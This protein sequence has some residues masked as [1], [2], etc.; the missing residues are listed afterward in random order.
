MA[1]AIGTAGS[2]ALLKKL[3]GWRPGKDDVAMAGIELGVKW[4][5][6]TRVVEYVWINYGELM[7]LSWNS[8]C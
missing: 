6:M 7:F 8:L 4:G 3:H 1:T 5:D 2:S